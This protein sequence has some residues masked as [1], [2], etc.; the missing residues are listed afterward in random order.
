MSIVALFSIFGAGLV[1]GLFGTL[2]G[3]GSLLTIPVLILLGLTPH[4]AI[5]TDRLGVTGVGIAGLYTFH[6]KGLVNYG[7]GFLVGI[8]VLIGSFLGA[9]LAFQISTSVMK[10]VI[11][12]MT[13]I[14]LIIVAVKRDIGVQPSDRTLSKRDFVAGVITSLVVGAYGGFY[15]AGAATFLF[16]IMVLIFRRTFLEAAATLKIA[17]IL[18]TAMSAATFA[19]HGAVHYPLA[20]AMFVGSCLGS[21]LGAQYSDRIGNVWIKRVFIGVVIL[22]VIKMVFS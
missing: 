10:L 14:L 21:F 1:G 3:G 7:I 16:Y 20:G 8:P 22:I 17:A 12:L 11:A 9:N 18:M 13:I 5:G 2:V 6:R 15:G 4:E 19:Y